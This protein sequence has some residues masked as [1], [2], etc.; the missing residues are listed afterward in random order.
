MLRSS[1]QRRR[2]LPVP[3]PLNCAGKTLIYSFNGFNPLFCCYG[4]G[5]TST[6]NVA[7]G[8]KQ[9]NIWLINYQI[10]KGVQLELLWGVLSLEKKKKKNICITDSFNAFFVLYQVKRC[11]QSVQND[12]FLKWNCSSTSFL[13][14]IHL[15]WRGEKQRAENSSAG[16]SASGKNLNIWFISYQRIKNQTIS[17]SSQPFPNVSVHCAASV[18]H[19]KCRNCFNSGL[20]ALD[21]SKKPESEINGGEENSYNST[22]LNDKWLYCYYLFLLFCL[23]D[24][25]PFWHHV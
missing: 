10:N 23:R 7:A 15:L 16:N 24:T 12:W 14:L 18:K 22:L 9:V 3:C 11:H 19:L 1:A 20:P 2:R 8:K 25:F 17:L 13:P 5:D 21:E 6:D 4:E